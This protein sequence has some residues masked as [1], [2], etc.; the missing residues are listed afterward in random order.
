MSQF[1]ASLDHRRPVL[2]S[3]CGPWSQRIIAE[4]QVI[5]MNEGQH[6]ISNL[7]KPDINTTPWE[8]KLVNDTCAVINS[9][10]EFDVFLKTY[11]QNNSKL[12]ILQYKNNISNLG[13]ASKKIASYYINKFN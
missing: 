13:D 1:K 10:E 3:K 2:Q 8:D 4:K 9:K 6:D 11:S 12:N 7:E 5:I